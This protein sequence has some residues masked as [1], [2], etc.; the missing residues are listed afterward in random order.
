MDN[1]PIGLNDPKGDAPDPKKATTHKVTKGQTLAK[2]S[3]LTGIS[4]ADLKAANKKIDWNSSKRTGKKQDWLY[5][6]ES[7]IIPPKEEAKGQIATKSKDLKKEA[8]EAGAHH[9]EPMPNQQPPKMK[10]VPKD[11]PNPGNNPSPNP[12][13]TILGIPAAAALTIIG[14]FL[15]TNFNEAPHSDFPPT[16]N[17][18]KEPARKGDDDFITLYRGVGNK[19][20]PEQQYVFALQGVA[21]PKGL[22][23]HPTDLRFHNDANTPNN[24]TYGN[25]NTFLTSWTTD[26][27]FAE[28]AA[29]RASSSGV[30]LTIRVKK[31]ETI[32]SGAS[33]NPLF[34]DEGEIQ[35]F[36]IRVA[37]SKRMVGK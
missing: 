35:L 20:M 2:L 21:V 7:I 13:A 3:K 9:L 14:V 19:V 17:W 10:V 15:P 12:T 11:N 25:N 32:V 33:L 29:L 34:A 23:P 16:P 1:N 27:S 26:E 28:V 30:I 24:H 5:E 37:D 31:S 22:I 4:I 36:G 8:Q 18:D 6:G